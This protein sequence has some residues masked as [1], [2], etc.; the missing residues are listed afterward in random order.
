MARVHLVHA[1]QQ[2]GLGADR[3]IANAANIHLTRVAFDAASALHCT[4]HA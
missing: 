1:A 3:P 2:C 4:V